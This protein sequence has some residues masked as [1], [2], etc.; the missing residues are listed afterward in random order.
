[1]RQQ[2]LFESTAEF[3]RDRGREIVHEHNEDFCDLVIRLIPNMRL[4]DTFIGE[5]VRLMAEAMTGRTAK[6]PNAWGA[7]I[8]RA[9]KSGLIV[10]TGGLRKMKTRKS[11]AR[12][13]PVYQMNFMKGEI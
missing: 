8:T 10:E 12:R 6:H 9:V 1:M 3:A 5:D 13:S 11:H 4:P 2:L 7:I